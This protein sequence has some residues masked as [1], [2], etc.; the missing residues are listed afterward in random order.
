MG[1]SGGPDSMALLHML[2]QKN[3]SLV[4][5]HVNYGVRQDAIKDQQIVEAFC[6][7]YQIP[8]VIYEAPG[9]SVGNFQKNARE[10]RFNAFK[11]VYEGYQ[12]NRLY[13]AH[14][15][16]DHLET[17]VFELLTQREPSQLGITKSTKIHGMHVVRPLLEMS[18]K[19]LVDYCHKQNIDYAIDASND[20]P[21]YTRNII[22]QK[23]SEM[24]EADKQLLLDYQKVYNQSKRLI[25]RKSTQFLRTQ[26]KFINIDD[27]ETLELSVRLSILRK[28]T[29]KP[30]VSK[31]ELEDL[32]AKILGRTHQHIELS[33]D[34]TLIIEYGLVYVIDNK[35][36]SYQVVIDNFQEINHPSFTLN[37]KQG[38]GLTV[39]D[40]DFPLTIR[41]PQEGDKIQMRY[42]TKKINRFFIDRKVLTID[43]LT[44]PIIVNNK[45]K[46]ICVAELGCDVDHY[47]EP[48]NLYVQRVKP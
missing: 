3:K 41:S 48:Y 26:E 39:R 28:I 23:L 17:I 37:Q 1:V 36:R 25:E 40:N 21:V 42:G 31:R 18:K 30:Q 45:G 27:Y 13:L 44:W 34:L 32:D 12:A 38:T 46:V 14:H 5:V 19:E 10:F 2:H 7:K 4:V 9:L 16:D 20:E 35:P 8:C 47:D 6:Q 29:Q 43:R 15:K 22:R 33:N 24:S 11:E